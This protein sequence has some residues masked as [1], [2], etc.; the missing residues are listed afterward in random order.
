MKQM[1]VGVCVVNPG[2]IPVYHRTNTLELEKRIK[3]I[4]LTLRCVILCLGILASVLVITDS[5]VKQVL[6]IEK[7]AKFTDMKSLV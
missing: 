1:S 5:Q 7:K 3:I 4:E 2:K 6:S